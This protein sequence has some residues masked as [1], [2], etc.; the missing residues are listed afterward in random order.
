MKKIILL[1]MLAFSAFLAQAQNATLKAGDTAPDFKLKNVDG[2][3]ISFAS[4]PKAKGYIVIFT[5]NTCPYA[6]GYEQRIIDLDNKFRPQGYPVIAI[7]PN[8]PEASKADTYE[9]MQELAKSKK[10]PFPYLFDAGQKI[11]DQ[12][13]AKHTPHL[14]IVSKTAKGNVVEYVGAIDNDP[15]GNNAQKTKYAEDVIASLKS[16]QKPAITQTKEIGCT[17]KRKAKA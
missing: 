1:V 7:N 9:K 8:D 2:K 12:Y 10:Y 16:N 13:G 4:F 15:E 6:V 5:C 11:T 14:F 17:V 3:D